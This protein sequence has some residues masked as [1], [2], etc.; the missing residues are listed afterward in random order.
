M[1]FRCKREE[2]VPKISDLLHDRWLDLESLEYVPDSH[3]IHLTLG[4][5][6][7]SA[8]HESVRSGRCATS[9]V[10]RG[11]LDYIVDDTEQVRYYDF[12]KLR[13]VKK[14]K[15]YRLVLETGVP[16]RLSFEVDRLDLTVSGHAVEGA[17]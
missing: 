13:A 3:L 6:T 8:S 16:L 10:I 11:V 7:S 5:P 1:L 12:N 17:E 2:C 4:P 9:L 15:L 14:R